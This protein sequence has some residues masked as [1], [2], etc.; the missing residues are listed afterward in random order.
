MISG[1]LIEIVTGKPTAG[2]SV[3]AANQLYKP[4]GKP[5]ESDEQGKFSIDVEG[6]MQVIITAAGYKTKILALQKLTP[7]ITIEPAPAKP[8]A[9]LLRAKSRIRKIR[10]YQNWYYAGVAGIILTASYVIYRQVN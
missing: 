1:Q 5:V 7:T 3:M 2:A 6:A 4:L 8:V 10:K 9:E